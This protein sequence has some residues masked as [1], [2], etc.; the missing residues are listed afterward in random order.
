MPV[1][2]GTRDHWQIVQPTGKWKSMKTPLNKEEFT[3]A[4]DLYINLSKQ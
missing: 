2:V 3:A 1:K 4:T